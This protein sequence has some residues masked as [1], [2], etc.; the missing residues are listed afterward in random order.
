MPIAKRLSDLRFSLFADPRTAEALAARGQQV[1]PL[2]RGDLK[3]D[4]LLRRVSA[5]A[6]AMVVSAAS[7]V[8]DR[9]LDSAIRRQCMVRGVP[10]LPT[11]EAGLAACVAIWENSR[12]SEDVRCLQ[13]LH[14]FADES[15]ETEQDEMREN[16]ALRS[17]A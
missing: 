14:G 3:S 6:M 4:E 5:G 1:T 13:E 16:L 9:E 17:S 11:V 12:R 10:F 8:R 7:G 15:L 2:K